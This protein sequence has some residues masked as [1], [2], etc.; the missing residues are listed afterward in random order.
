M[1]CRASIFWF[2]AGLCNFI[3]WYHY[4]ARKSLCKHPVISSSPLPSAAILGNTQPRLVMTVTDAASIDSF[5]AQHYVQY[6]NNINE[7]SLILNSHDTQQCTS[8]SSL[9]VDNRDQCLAVVHVRKAKSAYNLLRYD[10]SSDIHHKERREVFKLPQDMYL[11][12]GFF[13]KVNRIRG[14]TRLIEKLTPLLVHFDAVMSLVGGKLTSRGFQP[15]ATMIV[16][17]LNDG[18]LDL[19]MNYA[20]SCTLHDI[21]LAN[22]I[23]FTGSPE[24][25]PLIESTGAMAIFH[26]GFS[27]VSRTASADYIDYIF[28]DMMWYKAMSLFVMIHLGYNV[29]FQDVDWVMFRDPMPLVAQY[30]TSFAATDP[31]G[32][33]PDIL[34]SDDGNLSLR[35]APFFANSGFYYIKA[36]E[37]TEQLTWSIIESMDYIQ[38]LGSHQNVLTMR[39]MELT[40]MVGLKSQIIPLDI[41]PNGILYHHDRAFMQR[42]FKKKISPYGFHMCWTKGKPEKLQYLVKSN[43][44]YLTPACDLEDM[45]PPQGPLFIKYKDDTR[46]WHERFVEIKSTCC[47]MMK[48]A[49]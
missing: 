16:M 20:C 33:E 13:L 23:V 18:E 46:P 44:W 35:Y 45:I 21:A 6:S 27:E 14:R 8:Y 5:R 4:G 28:V 34:F 30:L 2:V 41:L 3:I 49:L 19:F 43:M 40:D 24:V 48:G 10:A 38:R 26:E 9:H 12:I 42:M 22:V 32:Q 11:P 1:S 15:G 37:K 36:N 25:I 39:M 47:T 31:N 29:L 7:K 17:T